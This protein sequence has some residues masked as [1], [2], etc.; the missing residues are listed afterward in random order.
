MRNDRVPTQEH[1]PLAVARS[2][3]SGSLLTWLRVTAKWKKLIVRTTVALIVAGCAVAFLLPNRYTAT[4]VLLPPQSGG[5]SS[6]AAMMAQLSGMGQLAGTGGGGLGIKNPNDLQVALLKSR[7][8]GDAMV[9]RFHLQ[10]LYR[11]KYLSSARKRWEKHTEVD[12]GLKDGLIHLSVTDTDPRR[13]E[14][15]ANGW[16][17]EY[18]RFTATLAITEASQRRLFYER[19]LTIAREDLTRAEE[20]M[21]QTE[22][23]TGVIDVDGQ[24]RTMIA[25][26]AVLRGQ[27]AS[28]QIEIR[29]MREFAAEQNPDLQRALQE[30][31]SIEGQLAAM[32]AAN[33]RKTGDLIAPKGTVTQASLDYVRALR[34]VK[35]RETVQDLLTRQYEGARVDE[36]RQGALVQVVDPA[37][38]PDKPTSSYKVW[39]A[40]AALFCSLPLALLAAAV[41]DVVSI[42]LRSRRNSNSWAAALEE[43]I[44]GAKR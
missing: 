14:E 27:L 22:Q 20:D 9:A 18:R 5:A 24:D 4:V 13:A 19:Q 3:H 6:S 29:A 34:E 38:V 23:R 30:L 31:A 44:V 40:L 36:A 17:E 43:L 2:T 1:E 35:Y 25:S 32:D 42:L 16:L 12:N 8:V 33:D 28:K 7:T 10:Q 21:K 26:A 41:C 39:I 37:V 15:L 11:R